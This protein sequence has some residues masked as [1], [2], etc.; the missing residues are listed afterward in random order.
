MQEIDRS[1][2]AMLSSA[3]T[4]CEACMLIPSQLASS[5]AGLR[6]SPASGS[7]IMSYGKRSYSTLG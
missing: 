1:S 5:E 4:R 7:F 2:K 3:L 6:R